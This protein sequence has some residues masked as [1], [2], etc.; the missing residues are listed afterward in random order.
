MSQ[1]Q[2]WLERSFG[3]EAAQMKENHFCKSG[4][5]ERGLLERAARR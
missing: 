3:G 5:V 4:A 2:Q 1:N